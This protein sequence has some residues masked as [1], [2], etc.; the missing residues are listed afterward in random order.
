MGKANM[1]QSFSVKSVNTPSQL[2]ALLCLWIDAQLAHIP[3][4]LQLTTPAI[5]L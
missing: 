3:N 4:P 5:N 2:G 1:V